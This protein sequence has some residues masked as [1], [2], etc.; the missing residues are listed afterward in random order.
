MTKFSTL[1]LA[2]A[3]VFGATQ[4]NAAPTATVEAAGA[5]NTTQSLTKGGVVTFDGLNGYT[6]NYSE[7]VGGVTATFDSL[8]P[9]NANVYGGAFGSKFVTVQTTTSI[10]LSE[11]VNYFGLWA[12]ALDGGNTVELLL[13]DS[14]VGLFNLTNTPLDGSYYGNPNGGGN[15]GEKYAFFN[16]NSDVK[17][18]HINL[19]ENGGGGFELD[20][21]TFGNTGAVPEP[22]TWAMMIAGFGMIGFAL[23]RR[24]GRIGYAA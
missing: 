3:A 19:V 4:A 24:I 6:A 22:A 23:R 12:S 7:T 11:A 5:Q 17:F 18:D 14:V 16:F 1:L 21:V 2:S 8:L 10:A 20:N 9:S 15:G 13:G